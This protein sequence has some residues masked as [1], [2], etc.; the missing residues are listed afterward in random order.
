MGYTGLYDFG[1]CSLYRFLFQVHAQ[2]VCGNG[3]QQMGYNLRHGLGHDSFRHHLRKKQSLRLGL[4]TLKKHSLSPTLPE[5]S[6]ISRRSS[7]ADRSTLS[8]SWLCLKI[9]PRR[10]LL[11]LPLPWF[12][13]FEKREIIGQS[14]HRR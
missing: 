14:C 10:T 3:I 4:F 7:K 12:P 13:I 9:Q 8:P 2:S 1:W 5:H 6:R 11:G